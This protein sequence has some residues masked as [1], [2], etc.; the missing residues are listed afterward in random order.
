MNTSNYMNWNLEELYDS[1]KKWEE[2]YLKIQEKC[3]QIKNDLKIL[4]INKLIELYGS[5]M[6]N[7]DKLYGYIK[8]KKDKNNML[9]FNEEF[10]KIEGI[11]NFISKIAVL[12]N[13]RML[14]NKEEVNEINKRYLSKVEK[15]NKV[16]DGKVLIKLN[17]NI[18]VAK[19]RFFLL[20]SS[21]NFGKI[22]DTYNNIYD[23]NLNSY[24]KYL[25]NTDRQL[26]KNA[27]YLIEKKYNEK[28]EEFSECLYE[29]I[30]TN[31]ELNEIL[32]YRSCL[33]SSL[34]K[35]EIN[36][37]IYTVCVDYINNNKS[38]FQEIVN[39]RKRF[40]KLDK[41]YLFDLFA[42]INKSENKNIPFEEAKRIIINSLKVLGKSYI[43]IVNTIFNKNWIDA[44]ENKNKTM[45]A[46]SYNIYGEHPYILINYQYSIND[47]FTMAHEIGHAVHY[48]LANN[49]QNYFNSQVTSLGTE[50]AAMINEC[51]VYDYLL[52]NNIFDKKDIIVEYLDK[53]RVILCKQSILNE[54]ENQLYSKVKNEEKLNFKEINSIYRE[55]LKEYYYDTIEIEDEVFEWMRVIHFYKNFHIYKY[56]IAFCVAVKICNNIEQ[57]NDD[58]IKLLK[59][60]GDKNII[61]L[62][63]GLDI[64]LTKEDVYVETFNKLKHLLKQIF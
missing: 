46:F 15:S 62:L 35:E 51:L 43:N 26:R 37:Q 22:K 24:G 41:L 16:I 50:I 29:Y 60:G 14:S 12:I 3:L 25:R 45:Y 57:Y 44:F 36:K 28:K 64:D 54:F 4:E 23:L 10:R 20:N 61:S 2:D 32:G 19:E 27:F 40:L 52:E 42:P 48:Y 39:C 47:V 49:N 21:M 5:L 34:E 63:K 9:N 55:I 1:N 30:K 31:I 13:E 56:I 11:D 38:I 7:R 8:L 58:Y 18:N 53:F 6:K 59:Q 33:E 17:K